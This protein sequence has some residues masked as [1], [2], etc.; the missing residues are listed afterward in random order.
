V[1]I[2]ACSL[3]RDHYSLNKFGKPLDKNYAKIRDVI[4]KMAEEA[5]ATLRNR[6]EALH[7]TVNQSGSDSS[8]KRMPYS[9]N[10][11]TQVCSSTR[12]STIENMQ[13]ATY[14]LLPDRVPIDQAS[15]GRIVTSVYGPGHDFCPRSPVKGL[16]ISAYTGVPMVRRHAREIY[17]NAR[18]AP[19]WDTLSDLLHIDFAR[20]IDDLQWPTGRLTTRTITNHEMYLRELAKRSSE[21]KNFILDAWNPNNKSTRESKRRKDVFLIVGIK[22]WNDSEDNT[23]PRKGSGFSDGGSTVIE[24]AGPSMTN[25]TTDASVE[26]TAKIITQAAL[27]ESDSK[28]FVFA[29]QYRRIKPSHISKLVLEEAKRLGQSTFSGDEHASANHEGFDFEL[30]EPLNETFLERGDLVFNRVEDGEDDLLFQGQEDGDDD[31]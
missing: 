23:F 3:E 28:S 29:V 14:L 4:V 26:S 16:S 6:L 8:I 15:L 13:R 7:G 19:I 12:Q 10:S 2:T 31:M 22:E 9:R 21:V 5:H 11:E 27:L 24:D 18:Y 1:G 25:T 30:D 20:G 17:R